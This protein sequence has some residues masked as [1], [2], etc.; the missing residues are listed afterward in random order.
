MGRGLG[1]IVFLK[2]L[3][4]ARGDGALVFFKLTSRTQRGELRS[5]SNLF[6]PGVLSC[7][8]QGLLFFIIVRDYTAFY[9]RAQFD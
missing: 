8:L 9:K 5:T 6:L 3:Y 4:A 7:G 2:N 1:A